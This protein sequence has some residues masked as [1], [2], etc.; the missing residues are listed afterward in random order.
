MR[1]TVITL[2]KLGT[3]CWSPARLFGDCWRCPRY[4]ICKYPE[5]VV[6]EEH[7]R[8]RREYVAARDRLRAFEGADF[9]EVSD[10]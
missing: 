5:K 3:Q 1:T 8:L 10:E 9:K 4:A 7:D 6:N 2:S